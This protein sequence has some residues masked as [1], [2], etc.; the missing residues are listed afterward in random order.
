MTETYTDNHD[1]TYTRRRYGVDGK[2]R[3]VTH[4]NKPGFG[5]TPTFHRGRK[6]RTA[7]INRVA[8]LPSGEGRLFSDYG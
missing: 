5:G 7:R 2:L 6:Q 3:E 1:G 4:Y 8:P